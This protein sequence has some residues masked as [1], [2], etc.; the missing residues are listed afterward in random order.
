MIDHAGYRRA[1]ISRNLPLYDDDGYE[2]DSEEDDD[3]IQDLLEEA[4]EF[5]PYATVH[6]ESESYFC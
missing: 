2:I 5:D 3:R 4:A 1:I 6:L